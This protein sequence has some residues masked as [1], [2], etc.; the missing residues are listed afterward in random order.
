[1]ERSKGDEPNMTGTTHSQGL[2]GGGRDLFAERLS[3]RGASLA[4]AGRRVVRFIDQN[5]AAVL[6]S[7]AMELAASTGTSDATVVRSVQALGFSG[8]GELRQALVATIT[9]PST[10]AENMRRTLEDV[11]EN[12]ARAVDLVLET[13]DEAL[14]ALRT[15]E[16]RARIVDAV[17]ALHPAERIVVFGIGPSAALAGYVSV[18]LERSGRRIKTLNTTGIMLADQLLDLR[19]GDAL[20]A[21]AYGRAY[22]EVLAVFA[23]AKRLGVP[24]VLVTDNPDSRLGNSA[25][26]VL[27][28]QRGRTGRMALHGTTL[29]GLEALVLGL[30]AAN[31][32]EAMAAL[33]HLNELRRAVSGQRIDVG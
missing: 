2:P 13:H 32:K 3:E 7:S 9:R 1:M 25:D 19:S 33:Q 23:E 15:P 30:T 11:G 22:R 26:V 4:P 17:S 5:R 16:A 27:A 24:I 6:A 31:Q 12:T 14:A 10:P 29:V 8:L 18:L 28:A 21:L 20:L